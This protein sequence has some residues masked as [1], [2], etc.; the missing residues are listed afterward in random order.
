MSEPFVDYTEEFKRLQGRSTPGEIV[1]VHGW[2]PEGSDPAVLILTRLKSPVRRFDKKTASWEL[3][4]RWLSQPC[5]DPKDEAWCCVKGL[6]DT[7]Y[8]KQELQKMGLLRGLKQGK[9]LFDFFNLF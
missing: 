1:A 4:Y 7:Y 5:R 9:S 3:Q 8:Q 2:N 6:E